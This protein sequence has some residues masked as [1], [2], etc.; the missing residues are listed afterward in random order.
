MEKQI[1][2]LERIIVS[3]KGIIESQDNIIKNLEE[4]IVLRDKYIAK[5]EEIFKSLKEKQSFNQRMNGHQD[6]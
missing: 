1:E 2:L 6:Y 3:Q 5:S 4:Q